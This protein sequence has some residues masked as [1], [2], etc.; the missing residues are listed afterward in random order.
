MLKFAPGKSKEGVVVDGAEICSPVSTGTLSGDTTGGE[1]GAG[2][3]VVTGVA[4]D[5]GGELP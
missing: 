5:G 2:A 3:G 1:L 4:T